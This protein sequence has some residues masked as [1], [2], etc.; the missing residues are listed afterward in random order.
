MFKRLILVLVTFWQG[1][2]GYFLKSM[3]GFPRSFFFLLM[4]VRF[5]MRF[6]V[7]FLGGTKFRGP[8]ELE[9]HKQGCIVGLW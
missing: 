7:L 6:F 5:M 8:L 2:V 3:D 9:R 4:G 1:L